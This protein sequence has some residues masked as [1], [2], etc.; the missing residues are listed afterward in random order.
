MQS[1]LDVSQ[2]GISFG[3]VVGVHAPWHSWSAQHEG[4]DAPQSEFV[5]HAWQFPSMQRGSLA[6]QSESPRHSTQP[7]EVSQNG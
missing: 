5:A 1:P 2:I 4:F 6:G 3:Q 7:S